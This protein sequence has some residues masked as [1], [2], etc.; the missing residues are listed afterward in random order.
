MSPVLKSLLRSPAPFRSTAAVELSSDLVF[1]DVAFDLTD[2]TDWLG[3]LRVAHLGEYVHQGGIGFLVVEEQV[4]VGNTTA[5]VDD[6]RS[7]AVQA[8]TLVTILAEDHRLA[9]FEL[10]RRVVASRLVLA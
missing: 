7:Q 10:E 5:K 3:E 6:F 4:I 2:D 9:M 8:D 1:E